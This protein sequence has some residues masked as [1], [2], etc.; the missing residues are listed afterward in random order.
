MVCTSENAHSLCASACLQ[1]ALILEEHRIRLYNI[2]TK[3][4]EP[5][6]LEVVTAGK[7]W[8][9][10][11]CR[12]ALIAVHYDSELGRWTLDAYSLEDGGDAQP[13]FWQITINED[14]PED[15]GTLPAV[16]RLQFL[17]QDITPPKMLWPMNVRVGRDSF[18]FTGNKSLCHRFCFSSGFF[19]WKSDSS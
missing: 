5:E 17:S 19:G 1:L 2:A 16:V 11:P 7:Q 18:F 10:T 15:V 13:L 14:L 3:S 8:M 9:C 12:T 6:S 4:W